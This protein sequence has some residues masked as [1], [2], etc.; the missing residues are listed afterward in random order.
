M[1]RKKWQGL[2]KKCARMSEASKPRGQGQRLAWD[3]LFE[4]LRV[5][6]RDLGGES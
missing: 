5:F 3:G 4:L 2:H 1:T 6:S